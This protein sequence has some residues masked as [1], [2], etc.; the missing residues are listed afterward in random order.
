MVS[1]G[2]ETKMHIAVNGVRSELLVWI[3]GFPQLL[4]IF[5]QPEHW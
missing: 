3:F 4:H 2:K 5:Y 1:E